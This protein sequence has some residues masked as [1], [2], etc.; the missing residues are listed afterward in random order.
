MTRTLVVPALAMFAAA[1][2]VFGADPGAGAPSESA[3]VLVEGS[4]LKVTT[5]DLEEKRA[6]AMFQARTNY[7]E[8]ERKAIEDLVDQSIL[9][10]QAKKEGPT[11]EELLERHVNAV[12]AKDPSDEALR[13]YY[14]GVDTTEP[15]ESVRGKIVD[16]LRQRRIAKAK[17][18]YM[19]TLR[20]QN[21]MTILLE[22][23][24]APISMK[25][26]A[27]RGAEGAKV[28]LLEF[29]DFQCPYCQQIQ[30]ALSKI[31]AEFQGKVTFAYKDYPLPMH[32][33][34]E[35]AAEA[36]H[37]AGAQGKYWDYHDMLF[38]GRQLD[39][40]ALKTY[41]RDLKLDTKA[42]ET[43]LDSGQM[44]GVVGTQNTEAQALGLQGTPTFFV[45]GRYVSGNVTYERLKNVIAEELSAVEARSG[46]RDK[47]ER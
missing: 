40:P 7:Y 47:K 19:S 13:V 5:K 23:P 44:A 11:V 14:E 43:C 38:T 32:A 28:T 4:G 24:R 35:K 41:A 1:F 12:I 27:V 39:P 16:A 6:A 21:P 33:D 17:T 9:D 3:V 15:F 31:E 30:P 46:S 42:F 10:Q 8:T 29:A 25:D 20:T 34:A 22:P 26:V 36:S 37:C 2:S 45:N 18:A